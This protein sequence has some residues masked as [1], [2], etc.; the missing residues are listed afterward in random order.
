MCQ[1][2]TVLP[3]EAH[4]V[5]VLSELVAC[6]PMW[7]DVFL[8]RCLSQLV[9]QRCLAAATFHTLVRCCCRKTGQKKS[10]SVNNV[11]PQNLH[12]RGWA[13]FHVDSLYYHTARNTP[14]WL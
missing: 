6:L 1:S 4:D 9:K 5:A 2:S 11:S 13:A 10:E 3:W 12:N 8:K 14:V 7:Y